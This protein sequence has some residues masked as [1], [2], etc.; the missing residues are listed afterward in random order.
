MRRLAWVCVPCWLILIGCQG[1]SSAGRTKAEEEAAKARAKAIAEVEK[2]G[3]RYE[4]DETLPDNPIIRVDL[5]NKKAGDSSL[6]VFGSLKELRILNLA[7]T[8]VTDSGLPWIKGLTKLEVLT[9]TDDGITDVGL[10]HLENLTSLQFLALG[11]T[12]ISDAG[13]ASLEKLHNLRTLYINNTPITEAGAKRLQKTLPT[14]RV[15]AG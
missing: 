8:S 6:V 11:G 10:K 9:L 1:Q 5:P 7:E 14:T 3:G 2:F 4:T 13:I 15:V 12:R